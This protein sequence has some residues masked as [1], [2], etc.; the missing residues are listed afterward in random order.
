MVHPFVLVEGDLRQSWRHGFSGSTKGTDESITGRK[1]FGGRRSSV[2]SA[3]RLLEEV[4]DDAWIALAL[5]RLHR[6]AD[7]EAEQLV[8]TAA[9]FGDWQYGG[10]GRTA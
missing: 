3:Q 10:A 1:P 8:L 9:I 5:H 6:L 2:A 4:V 7:E